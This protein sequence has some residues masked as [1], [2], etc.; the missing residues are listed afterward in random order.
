MSSFV[1]IDRLL[2]EA[3]RTEA[4]PG[5]VAMAADAN[6][7][8]YEGAFGRLRLPDGAPMRVDSIVWIASLTKALTAVAAM[9]LVE[10][11]RLALDQPIGA[12]IPQ[13]AAPHVLDGFEQDG[14]PR[15]RP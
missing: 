6:G 5:V 2:S 10:E 7:S 13:L 8:L 12:L 3:A 4:V 1:A 9:Q 14:A 11:G 15:L